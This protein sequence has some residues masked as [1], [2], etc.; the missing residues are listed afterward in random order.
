MELHRL[1]PSNTCSKGAMTSIDTRI[2]GNKKNTTTNGSDNCGSVTNIQNNI[3]LPKAFYARLPP[4]GK[5][6]N[7]PNNVNTT[8]DNCKQHK[9]SFDVR[10][11]ALFDQYKVSKEKK[12]FYSLFV[13]FFFIIYFNFF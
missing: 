8:I 12:D 5:Q 10:L 2:N 11:N 1:F 4:I 13:S 6:Q 3:R 7:T 9:D